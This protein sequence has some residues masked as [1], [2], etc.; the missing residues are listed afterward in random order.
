MFVLSWNL[1]TY[2]NTGHWLWGG[3][4]RHSGSCA[5]IGASHRIDEG[6]WMTSSTEQQVVLSDVI[7]NPRVSGMII[8]VLVCE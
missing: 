3:K 1:V 2:R 7:P 4:D 6:P 5:V 8:L